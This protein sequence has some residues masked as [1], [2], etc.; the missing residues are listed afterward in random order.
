MATPSILRIICAENINKTI[1]GLWPD[2]CDGTYDQYCDERRQYTNITEILESYGQTALLSYMKEYWTDYHG[3]EESFWEHEWGKH[4][5]CMSTLNPPC[6]SNYKG[7]EEVVDYF[8]RTVSLF[9]TLDTY[10]FLAAAGITPS[11]TR[12][13]TLES[14]NTAL[15]N[16][17][18]RAGKNAT[19]ECSHGQLD[20][21][22]Y[23]YNVIGTI[24]GGIF[25]P[26]DSSGAGTTTCPE[27]VQ[28][29]PKNT[30]SAY[31]VSSVS[32]SAAAS[33]TL[34][35]SPTCRPNGI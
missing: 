18:G 20:E 10:S 8:R 6:Y 15:R 11:A 5:T 9:Q 3:A 35:L 16:A 1:H 22:Y 32:S 28:Y 34:N 14:I 4:G 33:A 17:P 21:V 25:I 30:S 7:Q 19:V 2:H 24:A 27:S 29:L 23:P 26:V 13:Y 12:N 31:P